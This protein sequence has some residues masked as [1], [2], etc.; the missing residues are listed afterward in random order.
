MKKPKLHKQEKSY[1][2][3]AACLKMV[4]EHYGIREDEKTLRIKSKTKLYGTHPIHVVECAK[5]YGLDAYVSSLTFNKLRELTRKNVP[6][7]TNILKSDDDEFYVHSVV[8]YRIQKAE[9]YLLDPEDSEIHLD[10]DLFQRLWQ[11]NDYTAIVIEK[12]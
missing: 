1:S 2:C 5:S 9:V 6:V 4:L 10:N 7:I 8:I 11:S 3:M 12:P